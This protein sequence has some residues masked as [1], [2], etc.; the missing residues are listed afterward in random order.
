[1]GLIRLYFFTDDNFARNPASE[2]IFDRLISLR[3]REDMQKPFSHGGRH[4]V[5]IQPPGPIELIAPGVRVIP[6][7]RGGAGCLVG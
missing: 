2:Q 5:F 7:S 1:M 4:S 6:Q 3:E